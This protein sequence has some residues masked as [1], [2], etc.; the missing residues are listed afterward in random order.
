MNP[1]KLISDLKLRAGWGELGNSSIGDYEYQTLINFGLNYIFGDNQEL[2]QG[3]APVIINNEDIRWETTEQINF[4][5]DL[6]MLDNTLLFKTDYFIKN[7]RDA[8]LYVP[9]PATS[10]AVNTQR[11]NVGHIQNKGWEFEINYRNNIG[12]F[13]FNTG[14]NLSF[15]NNEIIDFNGLEWTTGRE[16]TSHIYREG[17]SIRSIFGYQTAGVYQ[18]AEQIANTPPIY[19][20]GPG[21]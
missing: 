12:D 11:Q 9:L 13:F 7:T 18:N 19:G 20:A 17:E 5:I 6:G 21:D 8:L 4:G 14:F 16:G 1:V 2:A 15:L 3:A 10:G